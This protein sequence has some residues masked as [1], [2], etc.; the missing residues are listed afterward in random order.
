MVVCSPSNETQ[1]ESVPIKLFSKEICKSVLTSL[2]AMFKALGWLVGFFWLIESFSPSPLKGTSC[3]K[4]KVLQNAYTGQLEGSTLG[5]AARG[6]YGQY[7]HGSP[8]KQTHI[9]S[10]KSLTQ[11]RWFQAAQGLPREILQFVLTLTFFWHSYLPTI[12]MSHCP[13][14]TL[15]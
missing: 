5:Y 4:T 8:G 9:A 6:P 2:T 1:I 13:T 11:M 14:S 15:P 12:I 3:L 7:S 10:L